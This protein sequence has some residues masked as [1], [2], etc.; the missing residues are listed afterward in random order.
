M[1]RQL[2]RF[3][4]I[5]KFLRS[6]ERHTAGSIA[7]VLE[8][9]ERTIQADIA[10]MRDR[11]DAPIE[12]SPVKG[13]HYTD[14]NWR[15]PSISLTEGELFALTLGARML[16]AYAGSAYEATLESAIGQLVAR[17]PDTVQADL[18]VLAQ[19]RVVFHPGA[20]NVN[21]DPDVWQ[22]LEFA[23][24]MFRSV[25]LVYAAPRGESLSER[26]IDPY[27]LRISRSNPYVTGFC[28]LRQALR[29]FRVDRVR[30]LEVLMDSFEIDPTF[31]AQ[32]YLEAPFFHEQGGEPQWVAIWFDAATAPYI[33]ERQWHSSQTIEEREDGSLVL[34]VEVRGLEEVKRWV[35]YYGAG[36]IA[37]EPVELAGMI[38][39]EVRAM[40]KNYKRS[41]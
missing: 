19:R 18:Q 13:Q 24:Q 7:E 15:L 36:A 1:S 31:D 22:K 25:R 23:S 20:T 26:V 8:V 3:L 21:F 4:T 9:S 30:S 16:A 29:D 2:E 14:P 37:L 27:L 10:F 39:A 5:D 17:L 11:F 33:R 38:R 12:Y 6:P 28:H 32:A 35:M 34:R 40:T 41:V